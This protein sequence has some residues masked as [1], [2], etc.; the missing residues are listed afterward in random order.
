MR[1][2]KIALVL[3]LE[4]LSLFFCWSRLRSRSQMN[5]EVFNVHLETYFSMR[6]QRCSMT[7][8]EAQKKV[9]REKRKID[10]SPMVIVMVKVLIMVIMMITMTLSLIPVS[11]VERKGQVEVEVNQVRGLIAKESSKNTPDT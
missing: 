4:H 11:V 2:Y 6:V 1:K 9:W 5:S 7:V 3:L 10:L 8:C